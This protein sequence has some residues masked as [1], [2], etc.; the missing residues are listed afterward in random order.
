MTKTFL[1]FGDVHIPWQ[2]NNAIKILLHTISWIRPQL[3]ICTGDLL[4]FSDWSTHQPTWGRPQTTLEQDFHQAIALWESIQFLVPQAQLV[5]LE[6]NHEYRLARWC[7]ANQIGTHLYETLMPALRFA[8]ALPKLKYIPYRDPTATNPAYY[9]L[10]DR[11][12]VVHGWT[13]AEHAAKHHLLQ[14]QGK[15]VIYGHTHTMDRFHRPVLHNP[16]RVIQA[17]GAGCLCKPMPFWRTHAPT[18][19][20]QGFILGRLR[21]NEES[22]HAVLIQNQQAEIDN[23]LISPQGYRLPANQQHLKPQI[24]EARWRA[25]QAI[26]RWQRK[27][28][29]ELSTPKD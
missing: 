1:V 3:V 29:L 14:A 13:Y 7:A 2:D 22:I 28:P 11:I 19:W 5:M 18:R 23:I 17:V 27:I 21:R 15:S 24:Q 20:V 10:E 6:G 26:M 8:A 12:V 25:Q 9:S 16:Y 4:D